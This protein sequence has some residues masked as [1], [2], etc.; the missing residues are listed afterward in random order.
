MIGVST[1]TTGGGGACSKARGTARP[2]VDAIVAVPPTSSP[3]PKPMS[4]LRRAMIV[5]SPAIARVAVGTQGRSY[6]DGR[7]R[8]W[9][10][11][12]HAGEVGPG[13]G[14]PTRPRQGGRLDRGPPIVGTSRFCAPLPM[15]R[16]FE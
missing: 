5:D 8:R 13:Q 6:R 3:A 1:V 14:A 10:G 15:E 9:R 11:G 4:P 7:G 2:P 12:G 16:R